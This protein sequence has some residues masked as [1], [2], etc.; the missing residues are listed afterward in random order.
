MD[1]PVDSTKNVAKIKQFHRRSLIW[2]GVACVIL[3]MVRILPVS[4]F[5]KWYYEGLFRW[6]RVPYDYVLGW[7]PFPMIYIVLLCLLVRIVKWAYSWKK[8]L[9]YQLSRALGGLAII[10]SLFYILWGFN[11]RQISLQDRLG[12]NLDDVTTDDV[13]TEFRRATE[14]LKKEAEELPDQ[15]TSDEAITKLKINDHDLRPDVERA[16]S[17]LG[18]PNSGRVRVRQL[19]PNGFLLRWSTAGIYIPYAC[20]GHIDKGL[21]SVQKPFTIAHEMAHGY[22]VTNEGACNFIA[23]LACSRSR[24]K[25]VRYGG[26]LTYWRYAAAE[27]ESG[28][29]KEVIYTLDPVVERSLLLVRENDKK[30]PDILPQIRDAIYSTYL[31]RHGVKGGLRSYN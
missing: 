25:W 31:K 26:A 17:E 27:I 13:E 30:Y 2:I 23:W 29:V 28:K 22:G 24:D 21:L 12:F 8:G 7:L 18:L 4:F 9:V 5:E 15:Y 11:Y 19:W 1:S 3:I 6:I 10:I 20:E 16:L 14:V